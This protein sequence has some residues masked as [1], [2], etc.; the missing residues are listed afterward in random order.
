MANNER[1]A[2]VKPKYKTDVKTK[3]IHW[4]IPI[5]IENDLREY[6]DRWDRKYRAT[7]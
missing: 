7:S 4:L 1:K 3:T 5:E 6:L 2:G